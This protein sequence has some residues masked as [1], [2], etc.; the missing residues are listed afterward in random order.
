MIAYR[1]IDEV[2][3]DYLD[4]IDNAERGGRGAR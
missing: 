4:L 3:E 1:L 2:I